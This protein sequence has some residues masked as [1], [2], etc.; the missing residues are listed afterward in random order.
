M[1]AR[2]RCSGGLLNGQGVH[3]RAQSDGTIGGSCTEHPDDTRLADP[4]VHCDAPRPQ[5]LGDQ[6]GGAPLVETELRMAMNVMP[7]RAHLL[8]EGRHCRK[9][10]TIH[11]RAYL[12]VKLAA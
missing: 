8:R 4:L 11:S 3:I 5:A 2:V 1:R 12:I 10:R 6:L 9:H 7:D